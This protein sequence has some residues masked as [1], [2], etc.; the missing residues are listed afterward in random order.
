MA[1]FWGSGAGV[2]VLV[3]YVPCLNLKT[4]S[5][6][7]RGGSH[8]L[9]GILVLYLHITAVTIETHLHGLIIWIKKEN[10][11]VGAYEIVNVFQ[12]K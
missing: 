7:Y 5:F 12:M 11:V 2:H 1:L 4:C 9:V 10:N 6:T 8:T 3:M